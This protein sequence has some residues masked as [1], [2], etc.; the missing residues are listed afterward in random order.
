VTDTAKIECTAGSLS[1]VRCCILLYVCTTAE[2]GNLFISTFSAAM[3]CRPVQFPNEQVPQEH[4]LG[5]WGFSALIRSLTLMYICVIGCMELHH[6]ATC[7]PHHV[8][9]NNRRNNNIYTVE[10][11]ISRF[12]TSDKLQIWRIL[13]K[14]TSFCYTF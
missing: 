5:V 2:A 10:K 11:K 6:H 14:L 7:T 12:G 3:S 13:W 9:S 1:Q 4:S 8:M